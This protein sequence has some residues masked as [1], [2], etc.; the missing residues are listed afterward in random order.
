[1]GP[2]D[3]FTNK[4]N[5]Y[6]IINKSTLDFTNIS[7]IFLDNIA[8]STANP[9][10][11]LFGKYDTYS[12]TSMSAPYVCGALAALA[13]YYKNDSAVQRKERLLKC[14]TKVSGLTNFC[15]TGGVLN[16]SKIPYVKYNTKT[17]ITKIKLNKKKAKLKRGK[18][19]KLKAKI[20]PS[21]A[22]N[23]KLKW[24]VSNKKYA[25]VNKK[26]VVRA[27]K[28]GVRHTVYVYA[29]AKD[30]SKKKAKCKIKI[31]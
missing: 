17:K 1:M 3:F 12:G 26:G 4:N 30:G 5:T 31:V 27:K 21:Y 23:K 22:D 19:L 6:L 29:K 28:K 8:I 18:K 24:Y 25:K 16:L 2:N 11:S 13:N 9:N 14:V 20:Y 10:T 15:S 7:N